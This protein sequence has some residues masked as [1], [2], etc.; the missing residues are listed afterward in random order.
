M[1]GEAAKVGEMRD[2]LLI[3]YYQSIIR[4]MNVCGKFC[5]EIG[6]G[7]EHMGEVSDVGLLGSYAL[8][9]GK[10]LVEREMGEVWSSFDAVDRNGFQALQLLKLLILDKIHIRQIC[11]IPKTVSQNG[12]TFL[13][14]VPALDGDY[15]HLGDGTFDRRPLVVITLSGN[16]YKGRFCSI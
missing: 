13:F 1:S 8:E 9:E 5:V 15:F 7:W 6:V 11:N 2:C 14:V 4:R 3:L 16:P 12:K 10:S